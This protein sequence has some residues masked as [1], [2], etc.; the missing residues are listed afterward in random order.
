MVPI[1]DHCRCK[2]ACSCTCGVMCLNPMLIAFKP[3]TSEFPR[4]DIHEII[5]PDI[6]H[7]VIKGTFKDH[8]VAW[9]EDYLVLTHGRNNA[10]LILDDIDRRSVSSLMT[11][12]SLTHTTPPFSIA[13]LP[14]FPGLRRF[15]QGRGFKQWTGDDSKALMKVSSLST[16][17]QSLHG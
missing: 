15:P 13:L 6:L 8:L 12:S 10:N 14:S 11:L 2:G 9:V 4:A 16:H 5:A 1:R 3:F 7:Q 17:I